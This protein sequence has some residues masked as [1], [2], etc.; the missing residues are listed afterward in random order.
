MAIGPKYSVPFKNFM[1]SS[2]LL[3]QQLENAIK[4]GH[5]GGGGGGGKEAGGRREAGRTSQ[6][7]SIKLKM[8]FSN[9]K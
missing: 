8:D 7:P 9:F 1:Q 6:A 2:P 3:R 5:G 4:A